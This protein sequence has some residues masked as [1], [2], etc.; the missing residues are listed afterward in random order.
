[1]KLFRLRVKRFET[2]IKMNPKNKELKL[3]LEQYRKEFEEHYGNSYHINN[4]RDK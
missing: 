2:L 3:E 1:M 4:R